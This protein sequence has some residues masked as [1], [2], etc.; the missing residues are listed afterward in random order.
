MTVHFLHALDRFQT[1]AS[2]S[3]FRRKNAL[4][5]PWI[6]NPSTIQIQSVSVGFSEI[7]GFPHRLCGLSLTVGLA[8]PWSHFD[9]TIKE[10]A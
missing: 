7:G 5:A 10:C 9:I 6:R 8:A 4:R 1:V 3:P 2:S